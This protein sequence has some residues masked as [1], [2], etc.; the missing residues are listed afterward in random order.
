MR[1]RRR[2]F[3][4]VLRYVGRSLRAVR[5]SDVG[6]PVT[7]PAPKLIARNERAIGNREVVVNC[8]SLLHLRDND[9]RGFSSF[10]SSVVAKGVHELT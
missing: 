6:P 1:E 3:C 7:P 8:H 4:D 5:S 10:A 9:I 2:A